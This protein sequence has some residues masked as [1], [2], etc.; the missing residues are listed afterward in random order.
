MKKL[1]ILLAITMIFVGCSREAE[2]DCNCSIAYYQ[3][4]IVRYENNGTTAV[5]QYVLQ[6]EN[7]PVLADCGDDTNGGY[8]F[9]EGNIYRKIACE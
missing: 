8:E 4:K 7:P 5:W 3:Y 9:V 6:T 2:T 1:F